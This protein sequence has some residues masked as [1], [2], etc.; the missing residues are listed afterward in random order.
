MDL[1]KIPL[2]E[3]TDLKSYYRDKNLKIIEGYSLESEEQE[4]FLKTYKDSFKNILEI[5]F[6]AGH[7]SEIFLCNNQNVELISIDLGF[8]YYTKF[9]DRFLSRKYENQIKVIYKDSIEALKDFSTIQEGTFFDLIYIDGNHEYEYAM[10]DML[11]CKKFASPESIVMLDDVI[12]SDDYRSLANSG[13]TKVW[14]ELVSSKDIIEIKCYHFK[15]LN[16]GVAIG[17]YNFNRH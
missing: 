12:L 7:S 16:R 1:E 15:D 17:K 14:K 10:A 4:L 2:S 8:W 11:N 6:N 9:G 13:P 5:G 3:L